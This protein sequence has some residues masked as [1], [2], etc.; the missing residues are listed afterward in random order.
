MSSTS[1]LFVCMGNICRSPMAEAVFLSIHA[2]EGTSGMYEIDSAGLLDYHEGELADARMRAHASSHGYTLA[3]RSRPVSKDDFKHFDL[4][5]CMDEQNVRG[6]RQLTSNPAHLAK[7]HLMT[8]YCIKMSATEV[9]DPYYGGDNG[10]E[11]VI[12]LL[13]DACEG[14]YEEVRSKR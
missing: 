5:I 13:E 4:I 7:I 10:F 12:D 1:I 14:L 9:P 2:R 8:D 11:Y 3:H 6:L